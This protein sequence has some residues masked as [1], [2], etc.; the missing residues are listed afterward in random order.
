MELGHLP[1]PSNWVSWKLT[2]NSTIASACE[3]KAG[4]FSWVKKIEVC[5]TEQFHLLAVS[6]RDRYSRL[7]GRLSA[8]IDKIK[9]G[10]KEI[11]R[12]ISL[13]AEKADKQG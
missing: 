13:E 11:D 6:Q 8:A 1:T 4:A 7:D 12:K 3:D 2:A 9:T 10:H 5:P